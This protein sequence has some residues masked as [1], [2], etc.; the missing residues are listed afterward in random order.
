[1]GWHEHLI[2]NCVFVLLCAS[3]SIIHERNISNSL[4]AHSLTR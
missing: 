3:G 2:F 1:M 4:A